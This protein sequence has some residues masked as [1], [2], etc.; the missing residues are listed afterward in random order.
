MVKYC[1]KFI[2]QGLEKT[3]KIKEAAKV[4]SLII[5]FTVVLN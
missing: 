4:T 5:L 3:H 2:L 1:I